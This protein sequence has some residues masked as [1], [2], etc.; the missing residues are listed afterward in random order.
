MRD[1]KASGLSIKAYCENAGFH[2]NVYYYWQKR[3]REAACEQLAEY[4]PNHG[5][6]SL[7]QSGFMEVKLMTPSGKLALYDNE[8]QDVGKLHF[9]YAGMKIAADSS[10][11]PEHIAVL[12]RRLV[13]S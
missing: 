9:E 13:Q 7:D 11:P 6:R 10:Y 12:L 2:E 3:L 1:R 5:T 4:Q 8:T